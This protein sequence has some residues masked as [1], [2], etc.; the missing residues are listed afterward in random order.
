MR[1]KVRALARI[2]LDA[3]RYSQTRYRWRRFNMRFQSAFPA[4][5]AA[6]LLGSTAQAFA[7]GTFD[8]AAPVPGSDLRAGLAARDAYLSGRSMPTNNAVSPWFRP[9]PVAAEPRRRRHPVKKTVD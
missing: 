1:D 3:M 8:Y 7:Q 4:I 6:L 9:E 2:R 5:L